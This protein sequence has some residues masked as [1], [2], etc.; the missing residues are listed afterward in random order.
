MAGVPRTLGRGSSDELTFDGFLRDRYWV[1]PSLNSAT[2]P[3]RWSLTGRRV[4]L[5][6]WGRCPG[7]PDH[8]TRH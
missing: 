6:A 1:I 2:F 8:R 3:P 4:I 5:N 7:A